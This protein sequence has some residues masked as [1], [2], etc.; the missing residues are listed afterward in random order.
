[1]T[2]PAKTYK[3]AIENHINRLK[4]ESSNRRLT[5][6]ENLALVLNDQCPGDIGIFASYFLN[7][8]I[9]NTILIKLKMQY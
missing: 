2:C 9:T 6:K 8:V 3:K 1:M 7:Y 5:D 4:S